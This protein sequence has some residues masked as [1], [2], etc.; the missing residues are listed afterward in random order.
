MV[1][2]DQ[3]LHPG[4]PILVAVNVSAKLRDGIPRQVEAEEQT[5][6]LIIDVAGHGLY[7]QSVCVHDTDLVQVVVS[8]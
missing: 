3:F 1:F 4:G 7:L 8:V 2:E 6:Q 5:T